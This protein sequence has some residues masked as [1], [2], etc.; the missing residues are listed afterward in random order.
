MAKAGSWT[1][2]LPGY[3]RRCCIL[4]CA[5]ILVVIGLVYWYKLQPKRVYRKHANVASKEFQYITRRIDFHFSANPWLGK[6]EAEQDLDELEWLLENRYSYLKLKGVDYKA[7]LD[8]IR[9]ALGDGISR[10]ALALQLMKFIALFGDGH[11]GVGDPNLNR[12]CPGFLPFLIG[13][14]EG[15]LV[16]FKA[17]RSSFLDEQHPFLCRI[18]GIELDRWLV[19][20]HRIVAKG[21]NQYVR[22]RSVRNLRYIQY[23]RKELG[24]KV[25][26]V[27]EVE[28]ESAD[29][30]SRRTVEVPVAD[31]F[32]LYGP[33]PRTQSRILPGN[34]GYLR[35]PDWMSNEAEFLDE[36]VRYMREFRGTEGLIIDIRG[37]GGGSRAPL[38]TLFPFFMADDESPKVQNVAAYKLGHR[39][40]ILDAR[41]LYPAERAHW[42]AAEK[43]SIEKISKVFEPEWRPPVDEFSRWHYFVIN[44]NRD[45][46]TYHY[47]RPVFILMS[48]TNFSASDIFLGA[49]KNRRN[50]TLIGTPSGGGSGRYQNYRLHN[51]LISIRLSSMASFQPNGKLYDGN[52]IQP[53]VVIE[54]IPTDFIGKTDTVLDAAISYIGHK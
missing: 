18:D 13:E 25:S 40:N 45:Q 3:F 49:F 53:D 27:A 54:P 22:L 23:L 51:S 12:M 35:I 46:G 28:L 21:S 20:A 50:V 44:P 29:G 31:E 11:S 43:R 19:V 37:I 16:A 34:I 30:H 47:D 5:A 26:H 2:R 15:R 8:T 7:A 48:R 1:T 32:P 33:W 36:L 42:T 10:G 17:D 24:L 52:G 9:S 6:K 41:W 4:A 39:V 38:R 14:S